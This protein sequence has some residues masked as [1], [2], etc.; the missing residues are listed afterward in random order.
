MRRHARQVSPTLERHSLLTPT[1]L[2]GNLFL[3]N[4]P[5]GTQS[6]GDVMASTLS[7]QEFVSKWRKSALK[8]SAASKEHLIDECR[9]IGHPTH[10][11]MDA[12]GWPHDISDDERL[13]RLLALNL[14]RAEGQR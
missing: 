6:K 3:A 11:E 2:R 9:L 5:H 10:A 14:E 8:E 4:P 13:E 7:D 12:Y 1:R